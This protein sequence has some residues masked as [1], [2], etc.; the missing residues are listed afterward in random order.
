MGKFIV[1][2]LAAFATVSAFVRA[3]PVGGLPRWAVAVDAGNSTRF[4]GG[5]ESG[6]LGTPGARLTRERE[7]PSRQVE[8]RSR[9][10]F[11]HGFEGSNAAPQVSAEISGPRV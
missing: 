11:S 2:G 5:C 4:L 8:D 3:A 7:H 6:A 10:R 9:R 1:G